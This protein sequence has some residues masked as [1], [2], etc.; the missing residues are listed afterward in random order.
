M[1]LVVG[2]GVRHISIG[3][4][5]SFSHFSSG[6]CPCICSLQVFFFQIFEVKVINH[7]S[8]WDNV[9]LIDMLDEWLDTGSLD[10]FFL[11]DFSFDVSGVAGNSCNEQ[12]WESMFLHWWLIYLA[13]IFIVFS[14]N[15]L[16]AC[17]SA[18]GEDDNPASLESKIGDERTFFPLYGH[19][20]I[21]NILK[22]KFD[23]MHLWNLIKCC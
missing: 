16:L 5:K 4:W 22:Y 3:L 20:I 11:V 13:A 17:I 6:C 14:D 23:V 1:S 8:G 9:I 10:E 7:K 15:G 2:F 19:K 12:V 21:V 18:G